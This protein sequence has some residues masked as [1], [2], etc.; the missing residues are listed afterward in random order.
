MT[1]GGNIRPRRNA[2]IGSF[3]YFYIGNVAY[4]EVSGV[5]FHEQ[6]VTDWL[7]L[8][9]KREAFKVRGTIINSFIPFLESV[10]E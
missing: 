7:S 5:E 2:N 1:T 4:F 6:R 8:P 3:A 10:H 9:Q